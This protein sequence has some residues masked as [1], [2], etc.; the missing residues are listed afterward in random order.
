MTTQIHLTSRRLVLRP[1]RDTD[2]LPFAE[3]SA[4]PKVME[5]LMP[6]PTR[7]ASDGWIDRQK[8]HLAAHGFCF[9]AIELVA[10]AEFIGAVG[11]LRVG[12]QAQ[13]TPAVEAGWRLARKFWGQGYVSE[14][15]EEVL[16]FGF[17]VLHL[18]EI[19]ANTAPNNKKSRRVMTRLGMSWNPAD[20]FDH[21][22]VPEGHHLRR[23]VLYRLSRSQ[24]LKSRE[25]R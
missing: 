13:F 24:W 21:P 7:E 9:W 4:D 10:S 1:W 12:Y 15:A 8:L 25:P 5:Y 14:A 3:L 2:R 19:V 18:S 16:H 11:L 20:D 22:L 17:E 23:Q 6:L